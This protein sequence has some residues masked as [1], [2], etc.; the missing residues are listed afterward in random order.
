MEH[1]V[2]C[3]P[4]T[5]TTLNSQHPDPSEGQLGGS[6]WHLGSLPQKPVK[7]ADGILKVLVLGTKTLGGDHQLPSLVDARL[8]LEGEREGSRK[9]WMKRR[10]GGS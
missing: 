8:E 6:L 10:K 5:K 7:F 2:G 4:I 9:G 1:L 3:C